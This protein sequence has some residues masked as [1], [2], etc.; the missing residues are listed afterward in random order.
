MRALAYLGP[1]PAAAA[2]RLVGAATWTPT[3]G[4]EQQAWQA[5]RAAAQV[6][7]LHPD[8][9]ER[10]PIA[11]LEAAL[12]AA[13]PLLLIMP[14]PSGASPFDPAERVRAALGLEA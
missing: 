1:E 2:W 3:Q 5:A 7:L 10:L 9:A 12:A 8:L 11:E 6:V 4:E 13:Q 14:E